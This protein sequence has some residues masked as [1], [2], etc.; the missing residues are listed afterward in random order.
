M[1]L[2]GPPNIEKMKAKRDVNGLCYIVTEDKDPILRCNAAKALGEIGDVRAVESLIFALEDR[3]V[4]LRKAAAEALGKIG[5]VRADTPLWKASRRD[6][7]LVEISEALLKIRGSQRI[8]KMIAEHD[9]EGLLSALKD[10]GRYEKWNAITALGDLKDV[11]AIDPIIPMLNEWESDIKKAAID[12]L[13]KIGDARAVKPMIALLKNQRSDTIP[14]KEY[15]AKAL[16]NLYHEGQLDDADKKL[17]LAER[18]EITKKHDDQ[19]IDNDD[20]NVDFHDDTGAGVDF[21][22]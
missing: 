5:D 12:A 8:K 17:I 22:L 15:V 7:M 19:H 2:F 1:G 9:V 20:Y 11:R 6:P 14:T 3:N 18:S 21:P 4:A 13:I 16:V 10:K